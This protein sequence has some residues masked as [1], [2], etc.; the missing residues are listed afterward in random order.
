MPFS[1]TFYDWVE[2]ETYAMVY[3]VVIFCLRIM[4][5]FFVSSSLQIIINLTLKKDNTGKLNGLKMVAQSL[6]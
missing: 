5:G 4:C 2:D 3:V 1:S 6:G